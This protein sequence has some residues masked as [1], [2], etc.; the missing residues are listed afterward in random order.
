MTDL[1]TML[2]RLRRP[3]LLIQAAR[4]GCDDYRRDTHLRRL[5]GPGRV[6]K[7]GEAL[8]RLI[9]IE[10][11]LNG[12]RRSGDAGYSLVTHVDVLIA[13]MGEARLARAVS[14]P[15]P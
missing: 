5:L 11:M 6:P 13:M 3:R 14:R 1:I 2:D 4:A 12:Q 15:A 7:S 10:D 8:I 9:E